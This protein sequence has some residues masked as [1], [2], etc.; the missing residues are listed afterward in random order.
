MEEQNETR[1][2]RKSTDL[3]A[4]WL[5]VVDQFGFMDIIIYFCNE[6]RVEIGERNHFNYSVCFAIAYLNLFDNWPETC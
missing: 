6:F 4:I 2:N 5:F 1:P 3:G